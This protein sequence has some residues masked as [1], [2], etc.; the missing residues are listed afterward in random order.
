MSRFRMSHRVAAMV[1]EAKRQGEVLP[2]ALIDSLRRIKTRRITAA[3][4]RHA[5]MLEPWAASLVKA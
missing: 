5:Q 3:M 2:P 1:R 4:R